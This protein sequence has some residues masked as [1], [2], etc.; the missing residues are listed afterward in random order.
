MVDPSPVPESR[1]VTAAYRELRSTLLG[2]LLKQTGDA[3]AAEDLL[4]DVM[5]K[6]LAS[7]KAGRPAPENIGAW[8][9]SV[10]RNAAIDWHRAR[11]PSEELP[12]DLAAPADEESEAGLELANC[13]RPMAERL[14]DHYRDTLLAAEFEGQPLKQ[15]AETQ[16]ISL[17][18]AKTRASRGRKLLQQ[19]L[20]QCCRV[21]LSGSGQVLDYDPQAASS[22]APAPGACGNEAGGNCKS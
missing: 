18:A 5:L 21:V 14:P 16:G 12:E 4:H 9:Y 22:C 11:R 8:L 2:V 15:I 17:A 10:A 3:H 13:L 19:E 1:D 7:E 6:V 20:V